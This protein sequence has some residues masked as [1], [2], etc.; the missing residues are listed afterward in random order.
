MEKLLERADWGLPT[1]NLLVMLDLNRRELLH[2]NMRIMLH[3][4][5]KTMLYLNLRTMQ[6]MWNLVN[7]GHLTS[8]LLCSY[9]A[10]S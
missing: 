9:P 4:N 6:N 7:C 3:V 2:M 8:N 10:D 5:L 1:R